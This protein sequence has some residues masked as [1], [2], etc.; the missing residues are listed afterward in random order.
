MIHVSKKAG[1]SVLD[2][3]GYNF[4]SEGDPVSVTIKAGAFSALKSAGK[5]ILVS[6]L[7][8]NG[9]T[10][11]DEFMVVSSESASTIE[12][13]HADIGGGYKLAISNADVVTL[14]PLI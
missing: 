12:L 1:Y 5:A 14:T 8:I 2:L 11:R 13:Y 7:T 3:S 9:T 6:G 4:V 10:A